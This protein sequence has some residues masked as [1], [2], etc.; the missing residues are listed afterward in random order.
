MQKSFETIVIGLGAMGSA[1]IYQL[2][3]RGN[4]VL[5][6]D[7]YA[8]PHQFGSS[9]GETRV[10]RQAIGEG[11]E[12][13]PLVLRSYEIWD[14]IEKATGTKLLTITG[15]LFLTSMEHSKYY[16]SSFFGQTV[17]VAEK[18]DIPHT[19]LDS[20][21]ISKRFPQFKLKGNEKGYFE[22][23]GGYLKAELC[24]EAQLRLAKS[25]GAKFSFDEKVIGFHITTNNKV[26]VKTTRNECMAEKVIISSGPWLSALLDDKLARY[27]TV[28]RQV[29]FW[30]DIE[31]SISEY[32]TPN[33]P[34]WFWGV[35]MDEED[36]M[37]GFPAI[38]GPYGGIKI[39][40][41][42]YIK[43]VNPDTVS[44]KVTRGEIENMYKSRIEPYFQGI[45]KKCLKAISCLYTVSPDGKFVIDFHPDYPGV[46]IASPCS[47]HGFKHSPAIG[48][49]LT[50][51]VISGKST[52]DIGKF[53]IRRFK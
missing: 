32:E 45:N 17:A 28:Y 16:G 40:S 31:N 13:V 7:Q 9:G 34:V 42:E 8:P 43:P 10:T 25:H 36:A 20:K 5:G 26:V 50:E 14:E 23:A 4:K 53:R 2:A 38:D 1:A 37:Y 12:Y 52:L 39:A 21:E 47:G 33:F 18:Y 3:K 15:W 46:I 48:E 30:F 22:P 24:I 27:F 41:E 51:L 19:L 35:G 11:E 44:R 6:I 29:L 49:I